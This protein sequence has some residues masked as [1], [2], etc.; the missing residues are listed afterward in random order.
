MSENATATPLQ[1][2]QP[3]TNNTNQSQPQPAPISG[4]PVA[5]AAVNPVQ[6]PVIVSEG[7]TQ[8]YTASTQD[9]GV[10]TP[11]PA[12]GMPTAQSA[13]P[14]AP[15][16]NYSVPE[17]PSLQVNGDP[18]V[19]DPYGSPFGGNQEVNNTDDALSGQVAEN[20]QVEDN[21]GQQQGAGGVQILNDVSG[22]VDTQSIGLAQTNNASQMSN[23]LPPE[24]EDVQL[25]GSDMQVQGSP[26]M[27]QPEQQA[28]QQEPMVMNEAP[29]S[30]QVQQVQGY[31]SQ[32]AGMQQEIASQTL[33]ATAQATMATPV[34]Q[35]PA[36]EPVATSSLEQIPSSNMYPGQAPLPPIDPSQTSEQTMS[37][38]AGQLNSNGLPQQQPSSNSEV[39]SEAKKVESKAVNPPS[40]KLLYIIIFILLVIVIVLTAVVLTSLT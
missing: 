2:G 17:S 21:L 37:T 13:Q 35:V 29:A 26:A 9:Y 36:Q 38:A 28:A 24:A 7:T 8:D 33:P 39:K 27:V 11:D 1:S 15:V 31:D 3:N 5:A 32:P 6:A 23:N 19:A 30:Q 40:N 14:T 25:E 18:S 10:N 12:M 20:N 4:A 16:E 34:N 22:E